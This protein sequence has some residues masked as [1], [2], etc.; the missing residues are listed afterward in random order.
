MIDCDVSAAAENIGT[1]SKV[2]GCAFQNL[3]IL[4]L[5]RVTQ[6]LGKKTSD[7]ITGRHSRWSSCQD[8]P[9]IGSFV[10]IVVSLLIKETSQSS[11]TND[12]EHRS[13]PTRPIFAWVVCGTGKQK[14]EIGV[15]CADELSHHQPAWISQKESQNN[16]RPSSLEVVFTL[17][18]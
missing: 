18:I 14:L 5:G 12:Q 10:L 7:S 1:C 11:Y 4:S 2:K 3:I 17:L 16:V 9:F 13:S 15:V 6:H 8:Q